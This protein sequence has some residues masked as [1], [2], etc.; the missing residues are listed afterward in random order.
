MA[1]SGTP[2]RDERI[3][4]IGSGQIGQ[5][6]ALLFAS[7]GFKVSL[8]DVNP[9]N[10]TK[11]QELILQLLQYLKKENCLRGSL[12]VQVQYDRIS[13]ADTIDA[14]VNDAIYVQECVFEDLELKLQLFADVDKH[15]GDNTI[16][17]SSTSSMLPSALSKDMKHRHNF[18]VVHP[19]NPPFFARAVELVPAPWTTP[20]VMGR[21]REL[22]VAIGQAPIVLKKEIPGFVL[23]R[24]Q[25][26]IV[27]E[28]YRL[29]KKGVISVDGCNKTISEGIGPRY[30]FMGPF[31]TAH[32]NADGFQNYCDRYGDIIYRVQQSFG[33][34]EKMEGELVQQIQ[35]ELVKKVPLD[36][37]DERRRWRERRMAALNKLKTELAQQGQNA[38]DSGK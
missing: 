18:L 27:G 4:I 6:W 7:A 34:P 13:K 25:F 3:A 16:V 10:V 30:A 38:T 29:V 28:C 23:N 9:E 22:M 15:I 21:T 20:E 32:L 35:N 37:L 26:A 36:K 24:M 17:G 5:S 12:P 19:T 1:S 33:P 11:A 2:L 8:Y 31:Q 14:C